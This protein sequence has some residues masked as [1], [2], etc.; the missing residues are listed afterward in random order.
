[1][2]HPRHQYQHRTSTRPFK[3]YQENLAPRFGRSGGDYDILALSRPSGCASALRRPVPP[4]LKPPDG[5]DGPVLSL[6][7]QV[8][9]PRILGRAGPL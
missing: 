9:V 3:K 5:M 2:Y 1:M 6:Q 7:V 4:V 8:Q